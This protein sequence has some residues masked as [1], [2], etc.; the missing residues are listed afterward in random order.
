MPWKWDIY[1]RKIHD[2]SAEWIT[3]FTNYI[4]KLAKQGA[5]LQEVFLGECMP[6]QVLYIL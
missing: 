6:P 5:S 2:P 3:H 4:D 1:L